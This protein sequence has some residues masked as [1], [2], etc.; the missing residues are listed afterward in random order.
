MREVTLVKI[1]LGIILGICVGLAFVCRTAP[2][3]P[4]LTTCLWIFVVEAAI[5]FVMLSLVIYVDR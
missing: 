5:S 4:V 3:E 2:P 1:V